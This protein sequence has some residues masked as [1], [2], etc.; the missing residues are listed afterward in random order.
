[1]KALGYAL[2]TLGFLAGA[3]V[4][5]QHERTVALGPFLGAVAVGVLGVILVR[6]ATHRAATHVEHLAASI[7][8]VGRSLQNLVAEIDRFDAEK[9]S[10]DV[11]ELRHHIERTFPT[12]IEAFVEARESIAHSFGLQ[13]YA[14]VMNSFAAGERFLNR[15]WSAS[16]D[17]Y[18][19]EAYDYITRS[20]EQFDEALTKFRALEQKAA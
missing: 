8:T 16:T 3:F 10:I 6:V 12:E 2:I 11:Y 1:M 19:D 4:A 9:E 17:G 20:R 15:V 14:D 7:S 5:I 18:I 13:A